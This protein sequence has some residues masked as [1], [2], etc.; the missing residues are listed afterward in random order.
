[1]FFEQKKTAAQTVLVVD[2]GSGSIG[3]ALVSV[4]KNVAPKLTF[5]AR[6]PITLPN[7]SEPSRSLMVVTATLE[8]I[9]KTVAAEHV[10]VHK[11]QIIFSSPWYVSQTK[12]IKTDYNSPTLITHHIIDQLT[13]KAESQFLEESKSDGE[14]VEKRIIRTRLNGYETPNPYNKKAKNVE[15]AFFSSLVARDVLESVRRVIGKYFHV[16]NSK[17]SVF[18]LVAFSAISRILPNERDF[19]I[20]DV[21]GE[22]TDVSLV[23]EGALIKSSSFPQGKNTLIQAV[24]KGSGQSVAAALSLLSTALHDGSELATQA[25]IFKFTG[26][27]KQAWLQAYTK[28]LQEMPNMPT[29]FLMADSDI[30]VFFE[31]ILNEIKNNSN[32]RQLKHLNL[33]DYLEKTSVQTDPFLA[34]ESIFATMV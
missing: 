14:V 17:A 1:M 23:T 26:A 31:N 33:K 5:S 16:R 10:V 27:F 32:L 34:L 3:A 6:L 8:S 4:S 30:E 22:V 18:S 24:M 21:R 11:T 15:I 9:M 19:L 7:E 29:V 13:K 25:D 20:V 28:I 2:V 12:I